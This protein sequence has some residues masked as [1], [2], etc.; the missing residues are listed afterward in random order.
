MRKIPKA[1]SGYSKLTP[2]LRAD[3]MRMYRNGVHVAEIEKVLNAS[4]HTVRLVIRDSNERRHRNWTEQDINKV[5]TLVRKGLSTK[6]I[7]REMD[8]TPAQ[9]DSMRYY[10][11]LTKKLLCK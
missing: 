7:A 5:A 10:Y 8:A 9:I 2:A 1:E 6:Q 11:N 4:A 3:I